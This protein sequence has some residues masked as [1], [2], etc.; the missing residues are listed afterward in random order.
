MAFHRFLSSI[1]QACRFTPARSLDSADFAREVENW[2]IG[3]DCLLRYES[4]LT[5]LPRTSQI[6]PVFDANSG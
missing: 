1:Q 3:A 6:N 4:R 2:R 5:G